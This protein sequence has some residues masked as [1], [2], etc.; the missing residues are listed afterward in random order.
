MKYFLQ[1]SGTEINLTQKEFIAKGGE[2]SIYGKGNIAY[3][4][5]EDPK[6]MIPVAKIQE[7]SVLDNPNI[8]KPEI[9][10]LDAK[11]KPIGYTMRLLKDTKVL[12]SLFTNAFRLRNN[13][14]DAAMLHLVKELQKLVSY[15]HSKN[16]L[17]VDLNEMNF[18]TDSRF[19]EIYA[20]DVNSYQT[21]N[22]PATAIMDTIRD[23]HMNG[24]NFN[25]NTD[26]FSWAVIA[27]QML[28]G[29]HPYR[30][31]H[32]AFESLHK[33]Q[34]L[35]ARMQQN[36]SV[37]NPKCTYPT[38][39]QPF[40]VIPPNL[41]SWFVEVFEKGY[42]GA[43]PNDYSAV[44]MAV[45]RTIKNITGTN[46]FE[47]V[48]IQEFQED[49]LH[50]YSYLSSPVVI[51]KKNIVIGKTSYKLP[52]TNAKVALTTKT[53]QP[54]VFW[55][56]DG[57]KA[58]DLK[59]QTMLNV[60]AMGSELFEI[61]GR[62]YLQ[63]NTHIIELMI[64]EFSNGNKILQKEVAKV[65]D[66]LGATQIHEGFI[67]QNVLGKYLGTFFP[68]SG[69]SFQMSFPEISDYQ[70]IEAKHEKNLLVVVGKKINSSKSMNTKGQYDRFVFRISSDYKT[71]DMWKVE[72]VPPTA[73]NF[74]VG[75][76]GI[77][78][79]MTED[80][81]L[82]AFSVNQKSSIKSMVDN[83]LDSDMR[84]CHRGSKIYFYKGKKL[85][86]ISMKP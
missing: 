19:K 35:N 64:S 47:I 31:N 1:G 58:M 2:G 73:I 10:L 41:R 53:Q 5:Y 38:I 72:D 57:V 65:M 4:V 17:V 76:H 48:E 6:K 13:I 60:P 75:D 16:V 77:A 79:L 15:I 32:P 84:L 81:H 61:D 26:W 8:I 11:N 3:K 37:F 71:Y 7:L 44:V 24:S 70:I 83:A 55:I 21:R 86:S 51:T 39:C 22:F 80:E 50:V 27:F 34:R 30:G 56:D 18:L 59:T 78:V 40:D 62:I 85:Y 36:V 25:E 12:V 23:R 63:N 67:M 14:D 68:S 20:I 33:N 28:I 52:S 82:E 54:I 42:R 46:L 69:Q 43:P 29:I 45:A 74:T 9:I 49:I 66:V